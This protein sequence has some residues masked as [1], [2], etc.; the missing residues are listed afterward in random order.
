[1]N[2][3]TKGSKLTNEEYDIRLTDF[4][5][6]RLDDYIDSKTSIKHT[7]IHCARI[8]KAKPKEISRIACNC[9]LKGSKY[10]EKIKSKNLELLE[11]Y[12][13]I[14]SKLSHKCLICNHKFKTTPKTVLQSKI[15]CPSCAGKKFTEEKYKSLL[16]DSIKLK[17]KYIDS[18]KH[19]LHECLECGYEWITK[20]NYILHMGCG[21]PECASSKGE[22]KIQEYLNDLKIVYIKEKCIEINQLKYRFDFF[23]EDLKSIIEFDGIQHFETREFFG[24][25]KYLKKI[26]KSDKVKNQWCITNNYRLVRISYKEIDNLTKE[27]LANFIYI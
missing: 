27:Q 12:K 26:K 2:Y 18:S 9:F 14:R 20:P 3:S 11:N 22:K 1:M 8:Y 10:K 15:G 19:T 17:G 7:C 21:C 5:L 24:G 6:K 25:E 16:P 23:I 13:N 4:N